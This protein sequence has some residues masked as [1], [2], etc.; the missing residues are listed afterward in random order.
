[1]VLST[2]ETK[3]RYIDGVT[4]NPDYEVSIDLNLEKNTNDW[5]S[6]VL[7]FIVERI[8]PHGFPQGGRIPAVYL[9][10]ESNM[11]LVCSALNGDGNVCWTSKE[12]PINTWFNL[13]IKQSFLYAEYVY[14]IFI[15]DKLMFERAN[16]QPTTFENV[17]GIIGNSF[18]P[19]W[20]FQL[21]AGKYKNFRFTSQ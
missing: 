20:D 15:D 4:V 16:D 8:N 12:M 14:E 13:K 1:M 21:A 3:W 18:E 10:K 9:Y 11:L 2:I 19:H 17:Q 7:S 5:W 6:N